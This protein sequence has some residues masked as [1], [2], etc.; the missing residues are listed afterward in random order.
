MI[1]ALATPLLV[2]TQTEK[3]SLTIQATVVNS[4]IHNYQV[5]HTTLGRIR[6][7]I[8]RLADDLEY[9]DKLTYALIS[10]AGV[11][12]VRVN[13]I[14]KS[15]IINYEPNPALEAQIHQSIFSAIEAADT[16]ILPSAINL[17]TL[18]EFSP[19]INNI[20]DWLTNEL[21]KLL[22]I[23][24]KDILTII[25]EISLVLGILG[26]ILPLLPGTPF[27]ILSSLCLVVA[28]EMPD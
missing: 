15:I 18:E 1:L 25:G 3:S 22:N 17:A 10:I 19:E 28:L 26:V 6:I 16:M 11:T 20:F 23:T 12:N 21:D 13:P 5:L 4:Q 14:A 2:N 27:L 8:P 7:G 9:S 24:V